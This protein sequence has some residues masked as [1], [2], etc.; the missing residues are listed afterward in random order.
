MKFPPS[1]ND[2]AFLGHRRCSLVC[3]QSGFRLEQIFFRA[4]SVAQAL[5]ERHARGLLDLDDDRNRFADLVVS[6]KARPFEMHD[7]DSVNQ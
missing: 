6:R 3:S 4:Y 2:H 1:G 5:V 7:F